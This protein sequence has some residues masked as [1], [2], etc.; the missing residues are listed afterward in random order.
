MWNARRC[1]VLG[2]TVGSFPSSSISRASGGAYVNTAASRAGAGQTGNLESPGH[3]L[4]ALGGELPGLPKGFPRRRDDQVLEH[5][6]VARI[7]DAG[8]DRD[9]DEIPVP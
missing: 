5:R 1:A 4:H 9:R 8:I 3:G 7:D 6:D 2:P